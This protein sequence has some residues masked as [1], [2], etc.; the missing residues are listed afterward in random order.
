VAL[1][2]EGNGPLRKI[3]VEADSNGAVRGYVAEPQAEVPPRP[4]GKLDV[5]AGLG[6]AGFLTVAK[7]LGLKK[8]YRGIVQLYTSEIAEDLAYY[9]TESEQTPSA[10]GLGVVLEPNGIVAAAGG[11]LVQ[12]LPSADERALDRL[13]TQISTL[14]PLTDLLRQGKTPEEILTLIFADIPI[15]LLEK[16]ALAFRC[17][18]SPERMERGLLSLGREEIDDLIAELGEAEVTC[19]FCGGRYFFSREELER[20]SRQLSAH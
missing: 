1:K 7:D 10:V 17:S 3:L 5:A 4:D 6:R 2:F 9:F 8:P 18:C 15:K 19:E 11:F 13:T 12:A 14:P 20:L 16:H